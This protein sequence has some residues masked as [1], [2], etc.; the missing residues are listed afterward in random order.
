MERDEARVFAEQSESFYAAYD[1]MFEI[2]ATGSDEQ[3]ARERAAAQG[4]EVRAVFC[5]KDLRNP[6]TYPYAAI[7]P[8][9]KVVATGSTCEYAKTY[10]S[11]LGVQAPLVL[12]LAQRQSPSSDGDGQSVKAS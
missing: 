12:R 10:A 4:I 3:E 6:N 8:S 1:R 2:V 11:I 9:G 5:L 7:G